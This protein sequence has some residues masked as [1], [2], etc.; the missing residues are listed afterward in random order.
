MEMHMRKALAI[1][2]LVGLPFSALAQS[3]VTLYGI[4]DLGVQWNE[5]GRDMG[6]STAPNWQQESAWGIDS[7]YQSGSRLG[8]RGSEALGRN[9]N[10]VFTLEAGFDASTG[11]SSQGGRLFGRQAWAG[12]QYAGLGTI[13]LGRIATPSSGSGAFDLWSPVDPFGCSWGVAG[14]GNT[15]I[16]CAT[17]REDNSIIWAS[18]SWS[19]FKFA[20]QY[21]ANIDTGENAPQGSNTSAMNF[22]ANWAWGPLFVAATYDVIAYADTGSAGRPGA[23]NPDQ[24][25]LQLGGT[26]DFKF[27]KVHAAWGDQSNISTAITLS[28]VGNGLPS[29]MVPVGIGYYDNNAWMLGVTVP[30]FGGSLRGS[31]QYS[32]AKNIVNGLAQFEPDYSV[33]GIGFDYPFSRRTNLYLG[34]AQREWDGRVT[35]ASGTALPQASQIFDRAQFALGLRH[36]F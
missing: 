12:L 22:G 32:D 26:F 13:A 35:Q 1:A 36:S 10:A 27:L 20:A 25:M 30:V 19:G 31:Y 24:K 9:W 5:S 14:L 2:A 11:T 6:T 3:S 17:L 15:F 4:V 21:S 16:P 33:W 28:G 29:A 23:G 8:L 7:G 34:Y 18:P